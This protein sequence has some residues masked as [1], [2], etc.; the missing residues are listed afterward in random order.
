LV[1]VVY[2][3]FPVGAQGKGRVGFDPKTP[4]HASISGITGDVAME[5]AGN[6]VSTVAAHYIITN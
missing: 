4:R 5:G 3:D 1:A 2:T 6:K